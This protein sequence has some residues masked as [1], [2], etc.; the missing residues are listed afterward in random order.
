MLL[1]SFVDVRE[2]FLRIFQIYKYVNEINIT[3]TDLRRLG[4][5][6][7]G[8]LKH[9]PARLAAIPAALVQ[10]VRDL[11]ARVKVSILQ[12]P[13]RA[14]KRRWLEEL[15]NTGAFEIRE[16]M[17][18]VTLIGARAHTRC[19]VVDAG[20]MHGVNRF[21]TVRFVQNWLGDTDT[22]PDNSTMRLALT[23]VILMLC[24]I[25]LTSDFGSIWGPDDQFSDVLNIMHYK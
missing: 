19:H 25:G 1:W 24:L 8:Y 18:D 12:R 6:F 9:L 20:V 7:V 3:A 21:P 15:E 22:G 4:G 5:S 2:N 14:V 11:H 10:D 16:L 17:N 13:S 23:G